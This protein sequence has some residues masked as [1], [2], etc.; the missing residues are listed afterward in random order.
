MCIVCLCVCVCV[1]VGVCVCADTQMC[2]RERQSVASK[3][4]LFNFKSWYYLSLRYVISVVPVEFIMK[5]MRRTMHIFYFIDRD[6]SYMFRLRKVVI[7]RLLIS[8][9]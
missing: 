3:M 6:S 4:A 5:E 2:V 9:V 7:I 8:E 1:C